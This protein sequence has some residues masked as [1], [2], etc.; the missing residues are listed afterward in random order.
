MSESTVVETVTETPVKKTRG[1][2][3][4]LTAGSIQLAFRLMRGNLAAVQDAMDQYPEAMQHKAL[5]SL[6]KVNP[7]LA[8]ALGFKVIPKS[9]VEVNDKRCVI[10]GL[11]GFGF[12]P[13]QRLHIESD[14]ETVTL[15]K[16]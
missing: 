8:G 9:E 6:A 7:D 11:G 1:P 10:L 12:Q 16:V 4:P 13:G 15:R 3:D 5:A 2:R 14:G